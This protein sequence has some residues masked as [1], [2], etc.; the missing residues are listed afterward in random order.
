VQLAR[1]YNTQASSARYRHAQESGL[2]LRLGP[3]HRSCHV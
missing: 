1:S 3:N 2:R